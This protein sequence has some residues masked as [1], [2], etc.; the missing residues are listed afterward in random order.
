MRF[1]V[2]KARLLVEVTIGTRTVLYPKNYSSLKGRRMLRVKHVPLLVEIIT[3]YN[4]NHVFVKFQAESVA[5]LLYK[6]QS[7]TESEV[8]VK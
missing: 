8:K 7:N 2:C 6:E 4:L 5:L 3:L 1:G